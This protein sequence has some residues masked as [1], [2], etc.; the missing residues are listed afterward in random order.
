M[1]TAEALN[2][3]VILL[4]DEGRHIGTAPK[5][6]VHGSDTALHLAFSC[7]VF[8]AQGDVLVTRRSLAK[9]AWPGVWTNSFCGHPLPGESPTDA[10]DRRARFELGLEISKLELVLPVF[11]Y[12]ATDSGG[13]VENE[14]CPVYVAVAERDPLPNPDEVDEFVWTRPAALARAIE[15]APWAF[16][17]WLALQVQQLDSFRA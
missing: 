12:R 7:H 13:T 10:V 2:E 15:D 8:N 16:S 4:D 1:H 11:R 3:H 17:P 6:I 5:S 9:K 14:I